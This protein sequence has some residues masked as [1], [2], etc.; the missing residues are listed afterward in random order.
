MVG[1]TNIEVENLGKQLLG[2]LFV[3]VYPADSIPNVKSMTNKSI[4]FNLSKHTEPGSH[5]VAVYF[6]NNKILYFDSYGKSLNNKYI[7]KN[8][9]KYK[10][11]IFYHTRPI[12][13]TNSIFCGL[14]TLAYLKATQKKKMT[15]NNF[16]KMFNSP[17]N[18]Q[19]DKIVTKFLLSK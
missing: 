3:G 8:L 12:Q 10:L 5:Y 13:D 16:Y 18:K 17:P 11:P 9:K 6:L 2:N 14:F 7:K 19:N 4:I 1:L 15:P